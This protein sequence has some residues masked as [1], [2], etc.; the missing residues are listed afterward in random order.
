VS[1]LEDLLRIAAR[2]GKLRL[3]VWHSSKNGFQANLARS[4]EG[5]TVDHSHDAL[6]AITKVLR[7]QWG[8]VLERERAAPT[9]EDDDIMG[10]IG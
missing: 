4:G 8:K 5:W 7:Q 10:L 2:S 3:H 1:D 9:V 6:T